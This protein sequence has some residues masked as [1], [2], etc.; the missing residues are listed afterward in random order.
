MFKLLRSRAKF[1]YWIIASTFILFTFVVWGAQCNRNPR[2]TS[3]VPDSVGSINGVEITWQEWDNSYKY[4]LSQVRQQSQTSALTANQRA[5]AAE[6]VWNG[7]LRLKLDAMEIKRRGIKVTDQEIID[8]L[9]NNPPSYLLQQY[10]TPEGQLDMD[11]YLSDLANP[12]RDW[13]AVEAQLRATLPSQRLFMELTSD[14]TVTEEEIRDQFIQQNGR[15]IAEY[16]GV[17]FSDITLDS[18][19]TPESLRAYYDAHPDEFV[20]PEMVVAELVSFP[21]DASEADDTEVMELTLEVRQEI[22]SGE[23]DFATAALW[24]SEDSSKDQGGDLGTFDRDRM[25]DEF[26][27]AAFSLPIGEISQPIKTQFGYHLIEVLEHFEED[28]ELKQVH[29]RHILFKVTPSDATIRDIYE[30]AQL[31]VEDARHHGFA[32]TAAD[33][34]LAVQRPAAT[35]KGWDL[36]GLRNTVEGTYFCFSAKPG[37]VSRAFENDTVFYVVHMVE[38]ID[39]GTTPFEDVETQVVTKVDRERKADLARTQLNPA[40]GAIQ[41]GSSFADAAAEHGL[42]HAV[43]DTFSY[44]GN[45]IGVGYNTEFNTAARE[46]PV[47]EFVSDVETSR[48]LFALTVLWKSAVDEEAYLTSRESMRQNLL[49]ERQQDAMEKWYETQ[50]ATAKIKD[51]RAVLYKGN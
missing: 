37:D 22:V 25:V 39:G 32:E 50:L 29:A 20:E 8:T 36:S 13:T 21:K 40:V 26:A 41:M 34:A 6:T 24:Y 11:A 9:K 2:N 35:R 7:L 10:V 46:H 15:A 19:A 1:F 18:D 14:V 49:F 16:V 43:T 31:F 42:A 12:E 45:I 38:K 51:N 28:G 4:Y 27:D 48:G 17:N 3:D 30:R 44:T 23:R 33:M 5:Q 47:G